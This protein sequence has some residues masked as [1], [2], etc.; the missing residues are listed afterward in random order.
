MP[1]FRHHGKPYLL[2]ETGEL[3]ELEEDIIGI[4]LNLESNNVGVVL[5]DDDLM[6]QEGSYV[7]A[8]GKIA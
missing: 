8:T 4:A 5:M 3:V 1:W 2:S 6:I 7:K